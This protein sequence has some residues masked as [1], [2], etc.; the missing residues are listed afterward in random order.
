MEIIRTG[1][2]GSRGSQWEIT[3]E[4]L[5]KECMRLNQ[6]EQPIAIKGWSVPGPYGSMDCLLTK[7]GTFRVE[8]GAL[9]VDVSGESNLEIIPAIQMKPRR[10]ETIIQFNAEH[11]SWRTQ[12]SMPEP[13]RISNLTLGIAKLE[14]TKP[15]KDK[16]DGN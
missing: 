15:E 12:A 5:Q 13:D 14:P 8:D 11:F 6:L 16:G 9:Y 4:W 3:E 2:Y 7:P 10:D 1:E